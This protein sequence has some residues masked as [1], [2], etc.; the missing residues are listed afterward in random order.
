[1]HSVCVGACEITY[2]W[3]SQ[4]PCVLSCTYRFPAHCTFQFFSHSNLGTSLRSAKD[5]K[6]VEERW[7]NRPESKKGR[8]DR[9][10]GEEEVVRSQEYNMH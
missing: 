2:I 5:G 4:C 9:N 10:S 7:N 3:S 6:R 8:R 1:M